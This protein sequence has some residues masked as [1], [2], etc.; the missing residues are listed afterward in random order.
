MRSFVL[1]VCLSV[2]LSLS[3]SLSLF[4]SFFLNPV[5]TSSQ[6]REHHQSCDMEITFC[7]YSGCL[8]SVSLFQI[9]YQR[10]CKNR[11][12][13]VFQWGPFIKMG[14]GCESRRWG[15]L[16][17]QRPCLGHGDISGLTV[18]GMSVE[19]SSCPTIIC[20][21]RSLCH[22]SLYVDTKYAPFFS[23]CSMRTV[24]W[25][26]G[27]IFL[28]AWQT[29]MSVQIVDLD[30]GSGHRSFV[31]VVLW[32]PR[33]FS[34]FD[35]RST[36]H[37]FR[38]ISLLYSSVARTLK[39]VGPLDCKL[40]LLRRWPISLASKFSFGEFM[41]LMFSLQTQRT[42]VCFFLLLLLFVFSFI[43]FLSLFHFLCGDFEEFFVGRN[44]LRVHVGWDVI[45]LT[46]TGCVDI[47]FAFKASQG[48]LCHWQ[49]S[50][51]F[52]CSDTVFKPTK[53]RVD[54]TEACLV[55]LK[56]KTWAWGMSPNR[57]FHTPANPQTC[58]EQRHESSRVE[59]F[60]MSIGGGRPATAFEVP[61]F[62][63]CIYTISPGS[64]GSMAK[65][66]PAVAGQDAAKLPRLPGEIVFIIMELI[67]DSN[68]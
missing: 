26:T 66:R 1:S 59:G 43:D 13:A 33:T 6:V 23:I 67:L 58:T 22:W 18:G 7:R 8:W 38:F 30:R 50:W 36:F 28:R 39:N 48:S 27:R 52:R 57:K 25:K 46:T 42:F 2:S 3:L 54:S 51:I 55:P 29:S 45:H 5:L 11:L 68:R 44:S 10:G 20:H 14:T 19:S 12:W 65:S 34:C 63:H 62:C 21:C 32:T 35:S 41:H 61:T 60:L 15:T 4:A 17:D 31:H 47:G 53:D 56:T 24:A 9:V 40:R 64:W 37:E 49:E 16:A